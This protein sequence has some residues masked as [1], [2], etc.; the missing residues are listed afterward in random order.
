MLYNY[1]LI[2][3]IC[4]RCIRPQLS[5]KFFSKLGPKL[6][7]ARFKAAPDT[8]NPAR[9]STLMWRYLASVSRLTDMR[10]KEL[11]VVIYI[12]SITLKK[13]NLFI[14]FTIFFGRYRYVLVFLVIH[15]SI[16]KCCHIFLL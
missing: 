14:N 5:P 7:P 4:K 1:D 16:Y 12:V 2:N 8:K 11:A 10:I 3:F 15:Y 6:A 9:F 13:I